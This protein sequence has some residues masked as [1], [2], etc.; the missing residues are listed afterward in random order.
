MRSNHQVVPGIPT[1]KSLDPEFPWLTVCPQAQPPRSDVALV[2]C[3]GFGGMNVAAVCAGGNFA[4][5]LMNAEAIPGG[6]VRH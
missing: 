3:R 1:L 6:A 5:Q 2:C 4:A